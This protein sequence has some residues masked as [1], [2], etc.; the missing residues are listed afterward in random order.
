MDYKKLK[1]TIEDAAKNAGITEYEVYYTEYRG[2]D[3][4]VFAS[5]IKSF[6]SDESRGICF[7]CRVNGKIGYASTEWMEEE[8]LRSLPVRALE[9][10]ALIENTDNDDF[11]GTG[12][13]YQ[14]AETE[15]APLAATGQYIEK[16]L[17]CQ[18]ACYDAD[19]RVSEGTETS[20][21]GY[22]TVICLFNSNGLDLSA[23][24][25]FDLVV[26][27]PVVRDGND[28]NAAYSFSIKS[29]D[30][31]DT[32]ALAKEAVKRSVQKIGAVQQESGKMPVIISNEQVC[33]MMG[34]FLSAFSADAAQKGLSLLAGKEGEQIASDCVTLIDDPFYADSPVKMPFDAE[35]VATFAKTVI[36]IGKLKTLLHNRKTA[37]KAG[38]KTTANASKHSYADTVSISPY[39]FYIK[40]GSLSFE[41]LL[42]EAKDGV[43]ITEFKGLHAGANAVTGDF[44]ID[45]EG[46]TIENGK[47]GH[48]VRSFTV[49]GNFFTLLQNI[50]TLDDRLLLD[51]PSGTTVLGAPDLLVD[52]LS[53]AGK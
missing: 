18:K 15:I 24:Y 10:A 37:K 32:A 17:S 27:A 46:F 14:K 11:Y 13:H 47:I 30:E 42:A 22:R 35:G 21:G 51:S 8:E 12:D 28:V 36:D 45:S 9:N 53:I 6:N 49:A 1:Y 25:G 52:G 4:S 50:R 29:L 40:P 39:C 16:A 23:A 33:T 48:A 19:S 26:T 43:Y 5:E 41:E 38:V 31:I 44:S 2:M 3:V 7:R 20:A 34:A